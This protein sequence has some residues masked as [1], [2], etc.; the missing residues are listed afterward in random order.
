MA[1]YLSQEESFDDNHYP[2]GWHTYANSYTDEYFRQLTTEQ[3]VKE[4]T[5]GG[6]VKI[7]W[8]Q[9]GRNEAFDLNVYNLA[10]ADLYIKNVSLYILKLEKP[11]PRSVFE[12]LKAIRNLT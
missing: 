8:K 5:P 4:I 12:Y 1:R 7:R 11:D 10:A 6:S 3:R 2:D 9:H